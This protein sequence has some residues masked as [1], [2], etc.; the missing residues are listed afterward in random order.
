MKPCSGVCSSCSPTCLCRAPYWA[1]HKTSGGHSGRP[2]PIV[3]ILAS[4]APLDMAAAQDPSS[5]GTPSFQSPPSAAFP[6][7]SHSLSTVFEN[8]QG[9][10][11]CLEALPEPHLP[12]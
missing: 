7:G 10:V 12:L 4:M 3:S 9:P 8:T 6:L 5:G 1:S 2:P 11:A